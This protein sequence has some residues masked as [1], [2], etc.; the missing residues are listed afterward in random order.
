[1]C[2]LGPSHDNYVDQLFFCTTYFQLV[3]DMMKGKPLHT[4]VPTNHIV[5]TCG[6]ICSFEIFIIEI[7]FDTGIVHTMGP[8]GDEITIH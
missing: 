4:I 8:T 5:T 7:L 6:I 3:K 2:F 1:M